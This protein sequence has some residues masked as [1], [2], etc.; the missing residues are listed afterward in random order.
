[1]SSQGA[2]VQTSG[3]VVS[4]ASS[5]TRNITGSS[6]NTLYVRVV[7]NYQGSGSNVFAFS[8]DGGNTYSVT[9]YFSGFLQ[10]ATYVFDQSD[11]TNATHPIRFSTTP[12]GSYTTGGVEF[13]TGVTYNGVAGQ[14]GA[15]T[16]VVFGTSTPAVLYYYC[17]N[18]S[19]MGRYDT[20][21]NRYGTLNVHDFWHL[22][23]LT[24]QDRQ[25]M[26]GQYS[27]SGQT[28]DGVD[29]YILDSGVRGASRPTG[30]NAALHP[31]LYDPD[32]VTDLNGTAEQQ[33]Y[34]VYQLSH[35]SLIHI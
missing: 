33:N 7:S 29:I 32:F 30:N 23:R 22:D 14:A 11:S 3:E 19:G 16:T 27:N 15:N 28:G 21:P 24:K 31:E 9:S 18:H 17:L 1:M 13:S 5:N 4:Q 34:R 6:T 12:D 2:E 26:N 10:G 35:L 25:Y 20:S 8:S